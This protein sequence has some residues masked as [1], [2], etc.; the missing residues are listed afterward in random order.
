MP[1]NY[2]IST[3]DIR[4]G[5]TLNLAAG[6][7]LVVTT[8]AGIYWSANSVITYEPAVEGSNPSKYVI[9]GSVVID[10]FAVGGSSEFRVGIQG[11]VL[12]GNGLGLG[13]GG[14]SCNLT[15]DGIISA[16][17]VYFWAIF[18]DGSYNSIVNNGT[19][20]GSYGVYL[21]SFGNVLYNAG[22]ISAQIYGVTMDGTSASAYNSG[23]IVGSFGIYIAGENNDLPSSMSVTNTGTINSE[24]YGIYAGLDLASSALT[25]KNSGTISGKYSSLLLYDSPDTVTNTGTLNGDVSLGGGADIFDSR[26]G[27]V[28]GIVNGGLGADTYFTNDHNL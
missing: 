9:M 26:S 21:G 16:T 17:N 12:V 13:N 1:T 10:T 6:D 19:I 14:S 11:S 5:Y 25:I 28:N 3:A 24:N 18:C 27:T 8:G 20:S 15:N 22:L 2:V 23:E 4:S 7:S